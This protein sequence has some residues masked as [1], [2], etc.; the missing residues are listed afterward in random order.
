MLRRIILVLCGASC[1][2]AT[3][4]W[5]PTPPVEAIPV[6]GKEE[7]EQ[8]L[9][10]QLTLPQ[11]LLTRGWTTDATAYFKLDSAGYA[12]EITVENVVNNALRDEVKRILRFVRFV[13]VTGEHNFFTRFELSTDKYN[14][15]IRQRKKFQPKSALR[16]DSS[17]TIY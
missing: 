3:A 14:R 4:Q 6:G 15:Y 10:T 17:F 5:L 11:I 9:Q 1:F 13:K 7:F 16:A 8:V 2:H 12:T